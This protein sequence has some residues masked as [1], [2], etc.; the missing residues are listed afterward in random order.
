MLL[1]RFCLRLRDAEDGHD[2]A[3][4]SDLDLGGQQ[5]DERFALVVAASADDLIDVVSDLAERGGRRWRG[6][7]GELAGEFV[8]AGT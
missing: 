4:A 1:R 3:W 2:P 7:V 6:Y 8:A 5:F